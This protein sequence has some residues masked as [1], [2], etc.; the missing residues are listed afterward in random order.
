MQ[1]NRLRSSKGFSSQPPDS[2]QQRMRR[3]ALGPWVVVWSSNIC[4]NLNKGVRQPSKNP[5]QVRAGACASVCACEDEFLC[6]CGGGGERE[7][8][9]HEA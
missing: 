9:T 2:L 3:V 5:S 6:V 1:K 4:P 8:C 7:A